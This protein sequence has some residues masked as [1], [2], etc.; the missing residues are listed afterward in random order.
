VRSDRDFSEEIFNLE[1]QVCDRVVDRSEERKSVS[2]VER[3]VVALS[4]TEDKNFSTRN[5]DIVNFCFPFATAK[6]AN[7]DD[8]HRTGCGSGIQ[9]A[10][11]SREVNAFARLIGP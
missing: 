2:A 7:F 11:P 10:A 9:G 3:I 5:C 1:L 6:T 4:L 8:A